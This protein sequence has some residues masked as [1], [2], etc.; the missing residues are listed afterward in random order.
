MEE[1][2]GKVSGTPAKIQTVPNAS[3]NE[4]FAKVRGRLQLPA[5]ARGKQ[6]ALYTGTL[7]YGDDCG[8]IV[9][10]AARLTEPGDERI[11][12][13]FIGDGKARVELEEQAANCGARVRFL[14]LMPKEEVFGWLEHAACALCTTKPAAFYDTCSPN[15][16]FDA[17]AAGVPVVQTTQGWLKALLEDED[18]GLTTPPNDPDAMAAA[19]RSLANDAEQ[20]QR[21]SRNASRLARERFDR[22]LLATSMLQSLQSAVESRCAQTRASLA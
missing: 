1:W 7:G 6:L 9:E 17:F 4:L 16:I 22:S 5:W 12:V 11:E 10:M 8:Q 2:I 13:V 3:D 21:L 14:G 20:Q 15:K 18:C 19:V